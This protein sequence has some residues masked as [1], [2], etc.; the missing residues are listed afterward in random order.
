VRDE[1][2]TRL[3]D[4]EGQLVGGEDVVFVVQAALLVGGVGLGV[5]AAEYAACRQRRHEGG[6]SE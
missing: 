5:G 4:V 3:P 1:L 6:E 2:A